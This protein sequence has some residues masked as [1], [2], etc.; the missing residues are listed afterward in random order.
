VTAICRNPENLPSVLLPLDA[1]SRIYPPDGT[2]IGVSCLH[3]INMAFV[4]RHNG[5][6]QNRNAR[7]LRKT[8]CFS[9]DWEVHQEGTYFTT[10]SQTFC[11]QARTLRVRASP[12]SQW[13]Q[14]TPTIATELTNNVWS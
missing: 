1:D 10:S 6:D 14:Q 4:E 13:Q 8:S 2:A 7:K 5:T 9:K 12:T 11:W 3:Q